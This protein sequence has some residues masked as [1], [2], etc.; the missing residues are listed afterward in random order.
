MMSLCLYLFVFCP[1]LEFIGTVLPCVLV[2]G[3]LCLWVG[4]WNVG[5]SYSE[6]CFW[7]IFV[8]VFFY[9]MEQSEDSTDQLN[10]SCLHLYDW[11]WDVQ[12]LFLFC[13]CVRVICS[14]I[15]KRQ[16]NELWTLNLLLKMVELRRTAASQNCH[17][18]QF[19]IIIKL[20]HY[21]CHS[22]AP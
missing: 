13:L 11:V 10:C 3:V 15:P 20:N 16:C 4:S 22:L 1:F 18:C 19:Q 6:S 7:I 8:S 9:G 21:E 17:S 2:A 5:S 14:A 12:W